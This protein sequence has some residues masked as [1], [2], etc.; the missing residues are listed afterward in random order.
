MTGPSKAGEMHLA[1]K[2][3]KEEWL[4]KG[5]SDEKL[6]NAWKYTIDS[7][8]AAFPNKQIVLDIAQ[9]LKIGN[10]NKVIEDIISYGKEKWV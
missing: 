5:Y 2:G 4:S 7:Y 10:P 1:A 6:V 9:P 8:S 3:S